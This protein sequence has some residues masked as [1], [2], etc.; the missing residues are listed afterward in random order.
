MRIEHYIYCKM[1]SEE[2]NNIKD[3]FSQYPYIIDLKL[4]KKTNNVKAITYWNVR[5]TDDCR[6][7]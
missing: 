6:L 1:I 7:S 5:L 3:F 2:D 4:K